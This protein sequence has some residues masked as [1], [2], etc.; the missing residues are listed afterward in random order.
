MRKVHKI[1]HSDKIWWASLRAH[2]LKSL[3]FQAFRKKTPVKHKG[4]FNFAKS[5]EI[6]NLQNQDIPK[7][8]IIADTFKKCDAWCDSLFSEKVLTME[9]EYSITSTD[10]KKRVSWSRSLRPLQLTVR[11]GGFFI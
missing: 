6:N 10:E 2:H 4:S 1:K 9:L 8:A 5:N 11:K 7:T 3:I